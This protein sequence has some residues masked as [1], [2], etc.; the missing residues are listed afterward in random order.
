MST[1]KKITTLKEVHAL[2]TS[3]SSTLKG[4]GIANGKN[5]CPIGYEPI[6]PL[7]FMEK[8]KRKE[9]KL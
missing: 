2:E 6:D 7:K 5:G 4:G 1:L 8:M 9:A 3:K